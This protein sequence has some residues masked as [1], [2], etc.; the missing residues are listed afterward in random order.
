LL[1][2]VRREFEE[3]RGLRITLPQAKRLFGL[4]EDICVRILGT[5]IDDGALARRSDCCYGRSDIA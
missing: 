1:C 5:L 2:R 4:R 3:M